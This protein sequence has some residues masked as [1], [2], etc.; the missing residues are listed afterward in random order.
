MAKKLLGRKER[1]RERECAIWG[2]IEREEEK[3]V[4]ESVKEEN[5]TQH[6]SHSEQEFSPGP[7]TT[8]ETTTTM[9]SANRCCRGEEEMDAATLK[10]GSNAKFL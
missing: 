10:K 7:S 5:P 8:K 2:E 3:I 1:E 6:S 9:L 4:R